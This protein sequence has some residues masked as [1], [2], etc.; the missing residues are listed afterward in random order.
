MKTSGV[1]RFL[2]KVET[3]SEEMSDQIKQITSENVAYCKQNNIKVNETEIDN[4][5]ER[6]QQPLISDKLKD[7][8]KNIIFSQA[9]NFTE[10]KFSEQPAKKMLLVLSYFGH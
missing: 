6:M 4:Y 10:N 2:Q 8:F 3:V 5:V 9:I 7:E 1:L